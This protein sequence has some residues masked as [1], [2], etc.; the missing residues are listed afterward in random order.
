MSD[1]RK[2]IIVYRKKKTHGG[3]HG[4]S[5]KVAYADFVTAM[6]AFFLVMWI[7]GME[8]D[9]KDL[10]QGYFN[11]PVGFR[12]AYGAGLDPLSQGS[13]PLPSELQRIP[14]FVRQ[15]QERQFDTVRGSILR[16]L[17]EMSGLGDLRTQVEVVVTAEGLRVELREDGEG[18]TFFMLGSNEVR[19]AA[20]RVLA[21]IGTNLEVLPNHIIIEGHTDAAAYGSDR[22]SNWELSVD[23]ANAA[24]RIMV[25]SGLDAGKVE[26]VR[27]YADR[28]LLTPDSPYSPSNRRVTV[29]I[30]YL[31]G[32]DLRDPLTDAP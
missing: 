16:D 3:H 1:D 9:V 15:V 14:L 19:P 5:W 4:G 22:Y 7:V 21:V 13:S 20:R 18:E 28:Q 6:M 17:E 29:L 32:V 24:R 8:S 27:G 11:N 12:R 31:E 2:V 30:P 25:E 10:V 23:R 26:E